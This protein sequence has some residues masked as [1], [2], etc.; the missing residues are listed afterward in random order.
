MDMP[1]EQNP[2]LEKCEAEIIQLKEKYNL[3]YK[4]KEEWAKKK[5]EIS[6]QIVEFIREVKRFK[7]SRNS[8]NSQIKE[9]KKSRDGFNEQI[10]K[11]LDAVTELKKQARQ[12]QMKSGIKDNPM[13]IKE[14][15]DALNLKLE[16]E[17]LAFTKEKQLM[18]QIKEARKGYEKVKEVA[19]VYEKIEEQRKIIKNVR[20][21]A[22]DIHNKV[23][24]I[25]K[26][27]EEKHQKL[28]E[29]SKKVD[30]L[31]EKEEAANKKFQEKKGECAKL[32]SVLK[33]DLQKTSDIKN[34]ERKKRDNIKR[35]QKEKIDKTLQ[36]KTKAVEEKFRL[37]KKLTKE[38]ILILQAK[39]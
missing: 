6:T 32:E 19:Q 2:E 31:K 18:K 27:S 16:T 12:I 5:S 26:K 14:N 1:T 17:A 11:D 9:L 10:K 28:L 34:K 24:Q 13:A 39:K 35:K 30:V 3:L 15:L 22:K 20:T 25:A 29:T 33:I 4:E 8:F 7:Q 37:K 36:D 38:D 21:E 23:Q